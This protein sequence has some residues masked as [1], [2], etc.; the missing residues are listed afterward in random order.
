MRFLNVL[1][2]IYCR[3]GLQGL[4]SEMSEVRLIVQKVAEK[5]RRS[6]AL[7]RAQ[8]IGRALLGLQ[9]FGSSSP[10]VLHLI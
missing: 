3:Y 7:L 2:K 6:S 1:S 10:E 4:S 5:M 8:H 9:R